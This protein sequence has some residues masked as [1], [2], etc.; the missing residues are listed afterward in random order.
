[1]IRD[2]QLLDLLDSLPTEQY[3]GEAFRATRQQLDPL[4]SSTNGGRWMPR[5]ES[6]VLYTSLSR[7]GALAELAYHWGL[8]SPLPS[9]PAVVNRLQV[10]IGGCL[11]IVRTK[12]PALGIN[13]NE[14]STRNYGRMQSIGAAAALLD[15][16]GLVVPSARWSTENLVIFTDNLDAD[17][18]L[19]S[20][21]E[22]EVDWQQ[23]ARSEN[24]L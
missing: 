4:A 17:D 8:L 20:V 13:E 6:S 3:S 19:E 1:M 9:K 12:F 5:G 21:N 11:R 24:L 7:D 23:W 16:H 2:H 15:C 22:E 14:Y 10:K 18:L